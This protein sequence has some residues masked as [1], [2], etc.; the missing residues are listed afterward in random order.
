MVK[1]N[2]VFLILGEEQQKVNGHSSRF[3]HRGRSRH[4]GPRRAPS[5][6]SD[7][8]EKEQ[9]MRRSLKRRTARVAVTRIKLLEASQSE[10]DC[11]EDNPRRSSGRLRNSRRPPVIQSSSES[12]G[13]S[14][15]GTQ[16]S[17]A[18]QVFLKV[19]RKSVSARYSR[20]SDTFGTFSSE[21]LRPFL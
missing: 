18:N 7:R 8:E 15:H 17:P 6:S 3:P 1:I 20:S 4:R 10:E 21:L 14:D 19:C 13:P 11:E 2:F 16:P 12:E 9:N 5:P